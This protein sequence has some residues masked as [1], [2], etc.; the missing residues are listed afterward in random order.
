MN[1]IEVGVASDVYAVDS[2]GKLYQRGDVSS[3]NLYGSGWK[4]LREEVS[5]ITTGWTG[6]YLLDA[7]ERVYRYSGKIVQKCCHGNENRNIA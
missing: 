6:Q 1:Q 5:T 3:T 7:D 4:L 2:E